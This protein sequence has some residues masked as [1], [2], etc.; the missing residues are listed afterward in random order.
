M[1]A[2]MILVS[3][4]R[5]IALPLEAK[6]ILVSASRKKALPLEAKV[7]LVSTSRKIAL[8]LEVA[9]LRQLIAF[10]H[11]SGTQSTRIGGANVYSTYAS[12]AIL[13]LHP[14]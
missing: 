12:V 13:T 1:E 10:Q 4:S 9:A 3:T 11:H 6:M 7:I 14:N 8:P 2:K 5:K